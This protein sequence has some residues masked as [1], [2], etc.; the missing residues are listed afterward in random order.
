M[1]MMMM[2]MTI[3]FVVL[4]LLTAFRVRLRS[5]PLFFSTCSPAGCC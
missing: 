4:S 3:F 1:M 5:S 2:M